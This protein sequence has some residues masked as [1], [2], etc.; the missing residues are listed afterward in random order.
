VQTRQLISIKTLSWIGVHIVALATAVL[1]IG[2]T[3]V[4]DLYSHDPVKFTIGVCGAIVALGATFGAAVS[5]ALL[6]A[7]Q[8]I[9]GAEIAEAVAPKGTVQPAV[10]IVSVATNAVPPYVPPPENTPVPFTVPK[11]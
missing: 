2:P 6:K 5:P 11:E 4:E 9:H 7:Y 8:I 3:M 1:M 10:E